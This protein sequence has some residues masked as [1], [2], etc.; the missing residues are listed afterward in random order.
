M[1]VRPLS[2]DMPVIEHNNGPASG[3]P[4][5]AVVGE[6]D[7]PGIELLEGI[8]PAG[9]VG[10]RLSVAVAMG[11][12]GELVGGVLR[13]RV[14]ALPGHDHRPVRPMD[15]QRLVTVGV[16]WRRHEEDSRQHFSLAYHLL[17]AAS[18]DELGEGVVLRLAGGVELS[19]LHE[20]RDLAQQRVA[21][22][23]V[24]VQMAVRGE[25]ESRDLCPD[26]RQCLVQSGPAGPVV[27]VDLG[28][29]AHASVEQ[30][31]SLGVVDDV[32]QAR[33]YPGTARPGLLRRPH[34]VA[35]VNAPHR[36]I[37]HSAILADHPASPPLT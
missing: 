2:R 18:L 11:S 17:E 34:E 32:T 9:D 26:R 24:E 33:F 5:G 31:H 13:R 27:G 10:Q 23:V 29:G 19:S 36:N 6:V 3:S 15:D 35:E 30:D 20:D 4:D 22:A 16:T 37:G 28:V 14:V 7:H 12:P 21:A 1:S 25:R 8:D